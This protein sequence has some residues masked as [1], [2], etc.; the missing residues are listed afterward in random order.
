LHASE[1]YGPTAHTINCDTRTDLFAVRIND[2]ATLHSTGAAVT[3]IVVTV[4]IVVFVVT[5]A[6]SL[7]FGKP[8]R[9]FAQVVWVNALALFAVFEIEFATLDSFVAAVTTIVLAV[10]I[11]VVVVAN[12]VSLVI[13]RS[14]RGFAQ[15][16]RVNA[17]A[18]F[19]VLE[20]EFATLDSFVA[21]VTTIVLAVFIVVVVVANAVSLVIGRSTGLLALWVNAL[22]LF[23]VFGIDFATFDSFGAAVAAIVVTP[24]I[25]VFVVT[26][27][28]SLV[29]GL[30]TH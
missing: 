30:S 5:I 25:V 7:V 3:A 2:L 11:V 28:V 15:V 9:G 22:A 1:T 12:A 8:A 21:A 4:F 27:A 29:I 20:I 14:A 10:F 18:L 6:I 17:R 23:A 26:N 16:L 19:A 24:F 13:G